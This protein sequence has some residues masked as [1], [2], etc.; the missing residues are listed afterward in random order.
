M[1]IRPGRAASLPG[2]DIL[3]PS[4]ISRKSLPAR[5][6]E[7]GDVTSFEEGTPD[8]RRFETFDGAPPAL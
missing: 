1:V 5:S 2:G 8:G 6:G 3:S 7:V 4:C